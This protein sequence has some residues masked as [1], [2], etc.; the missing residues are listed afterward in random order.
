MSAFIFTTEVCKG[1]QVRKEMEKMGSKEGCS[2][3]EDQRIA[4]WTLQMYRV[5]ST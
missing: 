1:A 3:S 4:D 5:G 2:G